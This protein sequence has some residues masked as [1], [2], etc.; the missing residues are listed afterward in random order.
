MAHFGTPL[1]KRGDHPNVQWGLDAA[2][3]SKSGGVIT[4]AQRDTYRRMIPNKETLIKRFLKEKP[5]WLGFSGSKPGT[6]EYA[7]AAK[8]AMKYSEIGHQL[9][10][11]GIMPSSA[12]IQK[13]SE[14]LRDANK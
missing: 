10:L 5:G 6:G 4:K 3:R 11:D 13:R 8:S 12:N 1:S 2:A 14:E 9:I 7:A